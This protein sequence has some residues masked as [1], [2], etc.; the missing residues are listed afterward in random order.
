M[1][2]CCVKSFVSVCE[3]LCRYASA[4]ISVCSHHFLWVY[5]SPGTT[6]SRER[7]LSSNSDRNSKKK[8]GLVPGT[9]D[10][11]PIPTVHCLLV[12]D[13]SRPVKADKWIPHLSA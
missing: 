3:R 10:R 1:Y 9:P 8:P 7:L 4:S 11:P 5:P 13:L 12:A 6:S 2:I